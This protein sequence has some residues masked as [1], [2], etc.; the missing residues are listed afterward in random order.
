[1]ER[2]DTFIYDGSTEADLG[3]YF[4]SASY[5]NRVNQGITLGDF[6][7][8][9]RLSKMYYPIAVYQDDKVSKKER[10]VSMI[11]AVDLPIFGVGY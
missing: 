10:F 1:M 8:T 9:L 11:E 6:E 2:D 4:D 7:R 3:I 5:F